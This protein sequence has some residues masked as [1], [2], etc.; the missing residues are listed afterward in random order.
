[1]SNEKNLKISLFLHSEDIKDF[2]QCLKEK[3]DFYEYEVKGEIGLEGM[4]FVHKTKESEPSWKLELEKLLIKSLEISPN[5]SNKAVL[6]LKY[7]DRFFSIV[8][9]YGRSMLNESSI[10]RNFGLR[11]TVNLI[12]SHKIRSMNMATIQDVIV[13]TQRQSTQYGDQNLFQPD[14]TKDLLRSIS[15]APSQETIA[16]FLVGSDSLVSTRKMDIL[17]IKESIEYYYKQYNSDDYKNNDFAWIDNIC[18]EKSPDRK[19][20]LDA[21]LENAIKNKEIPVIAPNKIVQWDDVDGFLIQGSGQKEY[22]IDIDYENYFKNISSKD[23]KTN[24]ITVLKRHGLMIKYTSR[25]IGEKLAS[26]YDSLVFETYFAN[27]KYILC[28]GNWYKI[29]NTFYHEITKKVNAIPKSTIAFPECK[30]DEV[31][32]DFNDRV[33]GL[34]SKYFCMDKKL[35]KPSGSRTSIELCDI[36]TNNF[37]FIHVKKGGSSSKLSHCFAQVYV[38]A[39]T[40]SA[41]LEEVKSFIESKLDSYST[42]NLSINN[43]EM[44]FAVID[45][46]CSNSAQLSDFLPFFSMVNLA[47]TIDSLKRLQIKYSFMKIGVLSNS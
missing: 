41:E 16:K 47:N 37:E 43:I 13:D 33:A 45:K 30:L 21:L 15:G 31:E 9:G 32:G 40:I 8:Y 10:V 39:A 1:M 35:F 23:Y 11:V 6:V 4:A 5:Q 19:K 12:G 42:Q 14:V 27:T 36:L 46:R 3:L 38:S 26:V 18:E 34:D 7:K 29:D 17:K 24:I 44:V 22:S 20:Q 25:D 2:K 28:Y